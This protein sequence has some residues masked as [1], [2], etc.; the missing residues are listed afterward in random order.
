MSFR[1]NRD[2][3]KCDTDMAL[4]DPSSDRIAMTRRTLEPCFPQLGTVEQRSAD[5]DADGTGICRAP[6][7]KPDHFPPI[8]SFLPLRRRSSHLH[9]SQLILW[10]CA[11]GPS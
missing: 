3:S 9:G 6:D 1:S 5:A 11:A 7:P 2:G 10:P 8:S 4:A